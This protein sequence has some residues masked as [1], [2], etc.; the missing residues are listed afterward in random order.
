MDHNYTLPVA[1][2]HQHSQG[3]PQQV[4]QQQQ[5]QPLQQHQHQYQ[6]QQ[7]QAS[8]VERGVKRPYPSSNTSSNSPTATSTAGGTGAAVT[9][10][11]RA[12]VSYPRK[13]AIAACQVCRGRKTKCD[14]E[15]PSCGFCRQA[16][17]ICVYE[18]DK[19]AT[20]DAASLAILDRLAKIETRLDYLSV[21]QIPPPGQQ[22]QQPQTSMHVAGINSPSP[23]TIPQQQQPLNHLPP[24]QYHPPPQPPQPFKPAHGIIPQQ[25]LPPTPPIQTS[26]LSPPSAGHNTNSLAPPHPTVAL[27]QHQ[28]LGN[29]LSTPLQTPASGTRRPIRGI[30][31]LASVGTTVQDILRWPIFEGNYDS[32]SIL[33]PVF[34]DDD[35]FDDDSDFDDFEGDGNNEDGD[36]KT[37]WGGSI[38]GP[39]T[40]VDEKELEQHDLRHLIERFL[41]NV[42]TKNPI[43]DQ[44]IL[45]DYADEIEAHGFDGSGKSCIVVSRRKLE[46]T[47]NFV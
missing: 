26:I 38:K 1:H 28:L 36:R 47:G 11:S 19:Q 22:L 37:R 45:E 9:T 31:R 14:N 25:A 30:A 34:E 29:H 27:D 15:R 3:H 23:I 44:A 33:A 24:I 46:S 4:Q 42:Q 12:A 21:P 20:F 13:R 8:H 7:Q 6:Q 10:F 18:G 39:V 43:L 16:G 32:D 40:D 41:T 5:Q 2:Q 35:E 17:A